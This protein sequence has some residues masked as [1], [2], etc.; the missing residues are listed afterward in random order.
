[1]TSTVRRLHDA[2]KR[3][4]LDALQTVLDRDPGRPDVMAVLLEAGSEPSQRNEHGLMPLAC[5]VGGA[6]GRWTQ[7][8]NAPLDE[9]RRAADIIR[10]HGGIE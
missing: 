8:S 4:D 5:A 10:S 2:V 7:F 9:W 3:G 6:A 1:M